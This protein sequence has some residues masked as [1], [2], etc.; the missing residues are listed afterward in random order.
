[1]LIVWGLYG[2]LAFFLKRFSQA[3]LAKRMA[4]IGAQGNGFVGLALMGLS[5]W[6]TFARDQ[7]S[8]NSDYFQCWYDSNPTTLE[9]WKNSLYSGQSAGAYLLASQMIWLSFTTNKVLNNDLKF[10]RHD[11]EVEEES[12]AAP[13]PA[14]DPST[15]H[16]DV[17]DAQQF[18]TVDGKNGTLVT[19]NGDRYTIVDG[20]ITSKNGKPYRKPKKASKAQQEQLEEEQK[21]RNEAAEKGEPCTGWY[22]L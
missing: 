14:V 8:T 15:V 11:I 4:L 7:C 3:P 13:A 1:M 12:A 22:C 9:A 2:W 20:K 17:P 5:L 21:E 19:K 18:E 16:P 10:R 6:K